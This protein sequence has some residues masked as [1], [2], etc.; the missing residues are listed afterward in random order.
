MKVLFA[1]TEGLPYIKS[2][3]LADVVGSLP[4]ILKKKRVDVR[5]VLPL[6]LKM[7]EFS[8][9]R[10]NRTGVVALVDDVTGELDEENRE[11]FLSL[12]DHADQTFYTL[13]AVPEGK[14]TEAQVVH[15]PL[16]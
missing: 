9:I 13:T 10:K 12:L 5:V 14:M 7:A 15:L 4:K 3:G 16:K 2:G 6:Y 11:R 8:L 1:A